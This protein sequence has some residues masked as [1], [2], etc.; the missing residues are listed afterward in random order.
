MF[1]PT[2][3]RRKNDRQARH[4]GILIA[5]IIVFCGYQFFGT[6]IAKLL[7]WITVAGLFLL[8][9]LFYPHL[10]HGITKYWIKFGV[11]MSKLVSPVIWYTIFLVFIIPTSI[12][13]KLCK[14]DRM[15]ISLKSAKASYWKENSGACDFGKQF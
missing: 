14:R 10:L 13:M 11:L 4:F 3:N 12:L 15:S 8:L 9:A 5:V 7:L 6:S 1:T 2:D